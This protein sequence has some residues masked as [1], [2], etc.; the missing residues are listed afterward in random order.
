MFECIQS[1]SALNVFAACCHGHQSNGLNCLNTDCLF[2]C[3]PNAFQMLH[4]AA[5]RHADISCTVQTKVARKHTRMPNLAS[6]PR[7]SSHS[8]FSRVKSRNHDYYHNPHTLLCCLFLSVHYSSTPSHIPPLNLFFFSPAAALLCLATW[9]RSLLCVRPY[10][11]LP[12]LLH[13]FL[14]SRSFLF[15]SHS[16]IRR[17]VDLCTS[18]PLVFVSHSLHFDVSVSSN[19]SA[20]HPSIPAFLLVLSVQ[21]TIT[22]PSNF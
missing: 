5:T 14:K 1:K 17:P 3:V 19:P 21:P 18:P 11:T 9:W 12:L 15:S 4:R 10:F 16:D 20:F 8:R 2:R 22:F 13:S 6:V 7:P